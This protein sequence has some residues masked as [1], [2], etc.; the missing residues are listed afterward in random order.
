MVTQ[1]RIFYMTVL[2]ITNTFFLLLQSRMQAFRHLSH[3]Q[4]CELF[5]VFFQLVILCLTLDAGRKYLVRHDLLEQLT[6]HPAWECPHCADERSDNG[7]DG[8]YNYEDLLS[9]TKVMP[10]FVALSCSLMYNDTATISCF[11]ETK[12][13]HIYILF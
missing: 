8:D 13:M 7:A 4:S 5:G 2:P 9:F 11:I 1:G 10:W 6:M 3:P 12:V